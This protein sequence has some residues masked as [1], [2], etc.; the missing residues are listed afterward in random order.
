MKNNANINIEI[1]FDNNLMYIGE[2]NS[3]VVKNKIENF[4][5]AVN[6]VKDYLLNNY[7]EEFQK[8]REKELE[9]NKGYDHVSIF[10]SNLSEVEKNAEIEK[11]KKFFKEHNADI[12]SIDDKGKKKLAYELRGNKEGYYVVFNFNASSDF[13]LKFEK[14]LRENENTLKFINVRQ[15]KEYVQNKDESE[16]EEL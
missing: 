13:M 3:S 6:R 15:D 5:E 11:Y 4:N 2:E 8:M 14:F 16:E 7:F 10:K 9:K 12:C 1:E